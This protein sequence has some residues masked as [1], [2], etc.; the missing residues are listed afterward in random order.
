[1]SSL[2]EMI[3]EILSPRTKEER[4]CSLVDKMFEVWYS[5]A[6]RFAAGEMPAGE[7]ARVSE[8]ALTALLG[9]KGGIERLPTASLD[10]QAGR[11][12][13]ATAGKIIMLHR[14]KP[15]FF[16][17][18]C[19]SKDLR[20][21]VAGD[22]GKRMEAIIMHHRFP[23]SIRVEAVRT[24][25]ELLQLYDMQPTSDEKNREKYRYDIDASRLVTLLTNVKC[26]MNIRSEGFEMLRFC[27]DDQRRKVARI[28]V[29]AAQDKE[30]LLAAWKMGALSM[31]DCV[32]II[33]RRVRRQKQR[34]DLASHDQQF[35]CDVTQSFIGAVLDSIR[36]AALND[37]SAGHSAELIDHR[38]VF[39]EG[40][41]HLCVLLQACD[42][43]SKSAF[44]EYSSAEGTTEREHS[45]EFLEVLGTLIES[46]PENVGY[47]ELAINPP[48]LEGL[49]MI[50]GVAEHFSA[51]CWYETLLPFLQKF[52][53]PMSI[54]GI[55][56]RPLE[57]EAIDLLRECARLH[58]MTKTSQNP[59]A[60]L[61]NRIWN[62]ILEA[63]RRGY[64]ETEG[65]PAILVEILISHHFENSE[66]AS[67]W[68]RHALKDTIC[69]N[70]KMKRAVHEALMSAVGL[71]SSAWGVSLRTLSKQGKSWLL[72]VISSCTSLAALGFWE[73]L[74]TS[75]PEFLREHEDVVLQVLLTID[76]QIRGNV[77]RRAAN[78][79]WW[80]ST[81]RCL[82]ALAECIESTTSSLFFDL[83][84]QVI[85]LCPAGEG[86]TLA[87]MYGD[88]T[89]ARIVQNFNG[90]AKLSHGAVEE[91]IRRGGERTRRALA[92]IEPVLFLRD[93]TMSTRL[94]A[95]QA[96]QKAPEVVITHADTIMNSCDEII[97]RR[98][99]VE[100]HVH[101]SDFA[102]A[103]APLFALISKTFPAQYLAIALD[104]LSKAAQ[105]SKSDSP[106]SEA[107]AVIVNASNTICDDVE[108][109]DLLFFCLDKDHAD[110]IFLLKTISPSWEEFLNAMVDCGKL[111]I[112]KSRRRGRSSLGNVYTHGPNLDVDAIV[113][114]HN[115]QKQRLPVLQ[116]FVLPEDSFGQKG[117]AR[118]IVAEQVSF[119]HN[120]CSEANEANSQ[121]TM[122][123]A[124]SA[125]VNASASTWER[126]RVLRSDRGE[127]S[128]WKW[129]S[130]KGEERGYGSKYDEEQ[131]PVAEAVFDMGILPDSV[132]SFKR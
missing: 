9:G 80:V 27:N 117:E 116:G 97:R 37:R 64:I 101:L 78:V 93:Q 45:Q 49:S 69:H 8:Q 57:Q 68:I 74:C 126:L 73:T 94:A 129:H 34:K 112:V 30:A 107:S 26:E 52:I 32:N 106:H 40:N 70:H 29:E 131:L 111:E 65:F 53:E 92:R 25:Q 115:S 102:E 15:K 42:E 38:K 19:G 100:A 87:S 88:E 84:L 33:L 103:A 51:Q 11:N 41:E 17:L 81:A 47:I 23:E 5:S 98:E 4:Q 48:S 24:L 36:E 50:A 39:L 55:S 123:T 16:K 118:G 61:G 6:R 110:A 119:M 121:S 125:H 114:R 127:A 31:Q 14:S 3:M 28:L 76:E 79:Q 72:S 1:M 10:R 7:M 46:F 75:Y 18:W 86:D 21:A 67:E 90:D 56:G 13:V 22:V 77:E 130:G 91:A 99:N 35:D 124:I 95:L 58:Y 96:I 132:P 12:L 128:A 62:T 60:S 109:D 122:S 2:H 20:D 89:L 120:P 83:T 54:R 66:E 108:D 63:M 44:V 85:A 82:R 113:D 59:S 71:E 43:A 104:G 105:S